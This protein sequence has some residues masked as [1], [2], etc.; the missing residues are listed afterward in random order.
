[1]IT[2]SL[3]D[4]KKYEFLKDDVMGWAI[5]QF[6]IPQSVRIINSNCMEV[7]LKRDYFNRQLNEDSV[8]LHRSLGLNLR[9]QDVEDLDFIFV[10]IHGPLTQRELIES[11]KE[12]KEGNYH[13]SLLCYCKEEKACFH[14]DSLDGHNKESCIETMRFF[15]HYNIFPKETPCYDPNFIPSQLSGWECGY[16]VIAF[17]YIILK[18]C[19]PISKR[20]VEEV[21]SN[22][23]GV[24]SI[25]ENVCSLLLHI[26]KK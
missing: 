7:C 10:I 14:Y 19:S 23:L 1:M 15:T 12:R 4:F 25:F 26:E 20:H 3:S 17:I 16:F 6:S 2:P 13:W 9:Y 18:E 21:Y 11:P 8:Q 24:D 22:F 5:Q